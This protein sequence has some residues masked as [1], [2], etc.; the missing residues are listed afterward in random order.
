MPRTRRQTAQIPQEPESF[1]SPEPDSSP[2]SQAGSSGDAELDLGLRMRV[3]GIAIV[4]LGGALPCRERK[5]AIPFAEPPLGK[6]CLKP[7]V[8][9]TNLDAETFDASNFGL[10]CFQQGVPAQSMS[11]DCLTINIFRPSDVPT[12]VKLPVLF[13]TYGG[14]FEAGTASGFNGSGIVAQSLVRGTPLVYVNF[15]Y[16]LGPLGF[17]QGKEADHHKAL[18]LAIKDQHA[19]LQWVQENIGALGGDKTKI[20]ES[21]S[22]ATAST[23]NAERWQNSWEAFVGGVPG[24]A[25]LAKTDHT[26]TCLQNATSE[27]ILQGVD[28]SLANPSEEFPFDPTID[29]LGGVYPDYPSRLF[30]RGHFAKLPFIAG[31]NLDEG[32]AFT[33]LGPNY[34]TDV[35]ESFVVAN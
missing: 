14:G 20:F 10:A 7:P 6:L 13:W 11:E 24:C 4:V 21:G 17:P 15:N 31:T 1:E 19:A 3:A 25:D 22:Q 33:L 12:D 30:E 16:R 34:T 9:K 32:T 2:S 18:N 35:I 29:G 8:L 28:A 23:F 5:L 27:E 26:F